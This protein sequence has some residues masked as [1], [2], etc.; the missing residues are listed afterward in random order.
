MNPYLIIGAL[1]MCGVTGVA[2]YGYGHRAGV[3]RTIAS[4]ASA[5]QIRRDTIE[6]ANQ[7]AA[8]AIAEMKPINTTIYQ[9]ATHEVRTNTVYDCRHS[10][11]MRERV[12]AA[13]TGRA[14]PVGGVS[15]PGTQPARR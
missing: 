7:G 11:G 10:D 9:K 5:E 6:A 15:V 13:L 2:G 1:L 4:Q 12:D 14:E 3:D 8:A